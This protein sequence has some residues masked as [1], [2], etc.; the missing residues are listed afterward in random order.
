MSIAAY[1]ITTS[2]RRHRGPIV[3]QRSG[4]S[5]YDIQIATTESLKRPVSQ[6]SNFRSASGL[7]RADDP[8]HLVLDELDRSGASSSA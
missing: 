5:P 7:P 1:N 3:P 4:Q 8:Y 2:S 6:N